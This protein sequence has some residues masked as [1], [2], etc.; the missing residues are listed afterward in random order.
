[1]K[2]SDLQET[3]PLENRLVQVETRSISTSPIVF[4]Q[5]TPV[6]EEYRRDTFERAYA[7]SPELNIRPAT[8]ESEPESTVEPVQAPVVFREPMIFANVSPLRRSHS[9]AQL[10]LT[11][12]NLR[13]ASIRDLSP[14]R[15][16][17]NWK[18]LP[19]D[20]LL[21]E[22]AE[23]LARV[24]AKREE[25]QIE[26]AS[27]HS[28]AIHFAEPIQSQPLEVKDLEVKPVTPRET[29]VNTPKP[30]PIVETPKPVDPPSKYK[31]Y[32][33]IFITL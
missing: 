24:K 8:P 17:S 19:K 33:L 7:R 15:R 11:K 21:E 27:D 30:A 3:S 32:V 31:R 23:H 1:L 14:P 2:P 28:K 20:T 10:R 26:S 13:N 29:L 18:E 5:E 6:E 16:E 4:A 25:S 22:A 9:A 12:T